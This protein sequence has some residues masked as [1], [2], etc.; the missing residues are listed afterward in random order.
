MNSLLFAYV[1]VQYINTVLHAWA[2]GTTCHVL[3]G[4][5][6]RHAWAGGTT[7]H[8]RAGWPVSLTGHGMHAAPPLTCGMADTR[9]PPPSL[10]A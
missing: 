10:A 6:T 3:A 9:A 1:V 8:V 5:T 4:G 7:C 2:G